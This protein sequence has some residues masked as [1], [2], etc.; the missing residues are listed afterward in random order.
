MIMFTTGATCQV[1]LP[2]RYKRFTLVVL[3][4]WNEDEG[5]IEGLRGFRSKEAIATR[6]SEL[7]HNG[8]ILRP[9]T[10]PVYAYEINRRI[11]RAANELEAT[12]R[13][14]GPIPRLFENHREQGY[15]IAACGLDV[16][17]FRAA[18]MITD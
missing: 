11:L 5:Q 14:D 4:G 1:P 9:E 3:E 2:A 6:F 8:K 7:S 18:P 10:V 13:G 12:E 15:R 16:V 17:L